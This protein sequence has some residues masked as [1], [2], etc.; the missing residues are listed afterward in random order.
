MWEYDR[1]DL[2]DVPRRAMKPTCSTGRAGRELVAVTA[3]GIAYFKRKIASPTKPAR[4]R[5]VLSE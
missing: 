3:N 1:L 4:Q 2:S 5:H